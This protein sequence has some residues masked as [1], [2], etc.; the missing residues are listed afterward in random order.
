MKKVKLEGEKGSLSK[1]KYGIIFFRS[2]QHR[3]INFTIGIQNGIQSC[4]INFLKGPLA[5]LVRAIGS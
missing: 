4:K 2:R 3:N 1:G 5:Q